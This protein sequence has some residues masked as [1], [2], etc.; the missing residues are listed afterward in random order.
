[1]YTL[2]DKDATA[3]DA[4]E[5]NMDLKKGI[6]RHFK[7]NMYELCDVVTHSETLEK[8]VLYR[9]L[10]GEKQLWVRPIEMWNQTVEHEGKIVKRFEF[11]EEKK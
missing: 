2:K 8:M 5:D 9:A 11:V 10:Y 4:G 1:M 7:G 6:Y 3:E